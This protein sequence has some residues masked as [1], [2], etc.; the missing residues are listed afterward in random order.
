MGLQD[1]FE[2]EYLEYA[3]REVESFLYQVQDLIALYDIKDMIYYFWHNK[4]TKGGTSFC[5]SYKPDGEP[6]YT[7]DDHDRLVDV[8]DTFLMTV[9]IIGESGKITLEYFDEYCPQSIR[10][11]VDY[12]ISDSDFTFYLDTIIYSLSDEEQQEIIKMAGVAR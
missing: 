7:D 9:P 8:G 12:D 1:H 2:P 4:T 5:N 3:K 6:T 10:G 11:N